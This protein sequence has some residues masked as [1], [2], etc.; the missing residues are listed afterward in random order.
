MRTCAHACLSL[1][2]GVWVCDTRVNVCVRVCG[3]YMH[4]PRKLLLIGDSCVNLRV[5]VRQD[6]L[7]K[8]LLIGD[9]GVG[10]SCLLLRFSDVYIPQK[11]EP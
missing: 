2:V 8:L 11:S 9:S 7:V 3:V 4:P 1:R 10:K 5:C 6:Y